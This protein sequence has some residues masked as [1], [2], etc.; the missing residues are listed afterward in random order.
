[1]VK[2]QYKIGKQGQGKKQA[3]RPQKNNKTEIKHKVKTK[4][5]TLP[6]QTIKPNVLKTL[7]HYLCLLSPILVNLKIKLMK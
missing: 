3:T 4:P 7:N 2:E 1:V 6:C 5:K